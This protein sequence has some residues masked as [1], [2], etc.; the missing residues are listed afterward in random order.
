MRTW[1]TRDNRLMKRVIIPAFTLMALI[2]ASCQDTGTGSGGDETGTN[3]DLV[4]A[5]PAE[6]PSMDLMREASTVLYALV[7]PNI[8]EGLAYLDINGD[9]D[10]EPLLAESWEQ[11]DEQ[12]WRISLRD[13]VNF[14]NGDP[15]TAE[16]VAASINYGIGEDSSYYDTFYST[17]EGAEAVDDTTVEVSLN[18]PD[19]IFYRRL[20]FLRVMP[21]SA[22][23]PEDMV[24]HFEGTG[25]YVLAEWRRGQSILLERNDSYWGEEPSFETVEYIIRSDENVR[26]AA[27]AAG[28][29]DIAYQVSSEAEEQV[30]QLIASPGLEVAGFMLN[31]ASQKPGGSVMADERVRVAVN[32]AIDR[33]A[34]ADSIFDGRATLPKCQYNPSFFV[35]TNSDLVD[36]D[37]DPELAKNLISEAGAE[38]ATIDIYTYVDWQKA[39]ELSEAVAN[40]LTDVGLKPQLH[41]MQLDQWLEFYLAAAEDKDLPLDMM[42]LYH[43][44]ELFESTVKTFDTMLSVE[45]G[46]GR[47]LI[48]DP[49]LDSAIE[50]AKTAE[51]LSERE[52]NMQRVWEIFCGNADGLPIVVPDF[53]YAA[54]ANIEWEPRL[55]A[56]IVVS[57]IGV[58]EE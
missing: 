47:W 30:P 1:S 4:I 28:E 36:Y 22:L 18:Q 52:G 46:G 2:A 57:E 16:D 9:G 39:E 32:H 49:E 43:S 44:N 31:G 53:L 38:G 42:N 34:I 54:G 50:E 20:P 41:P 14:S 21:E 12:T 55:N 45:G 58:R 56:E 19:P 37:Y 29:A 27:V 5:I 7:A 51:D 15:M 26:V 35:G 8:A 23:N 48:A 25:P 11:V 24:S 33:Q 13:D 6:P 40:Y 3:L 17:V 10:V